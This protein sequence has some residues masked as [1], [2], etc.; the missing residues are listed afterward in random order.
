M[1]T[2]GY[3]DGFIGP[4]DQIR[5][6]VL[7]RGFLYGDSVYEV[8]RTYEGIPFLFDEHYERLLHSAELSGMRNRAVTDAYEL[9]FRELSG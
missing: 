4:I 5:V 1:Q 2:T 3:I 6:P 9:L 7:D 8:F